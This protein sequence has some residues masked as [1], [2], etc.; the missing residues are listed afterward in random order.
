MKAVKKSVSIILAVFMAVSV[1]VIAPFTIG[2]AENSKLPTGNRVTDNVNENWK[3]TKKYF[4]KPDRS[5][6]FL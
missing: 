5:K 4:I 3:K 2:A 1:F 6:V